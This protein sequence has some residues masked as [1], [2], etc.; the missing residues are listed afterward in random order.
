MRQVFATEEERAL[1]RRKRQLGYYYKDKVRHDAANR[2]RARNRYEECSELIKSRNLAWRKKNP[3][4]I[5]AQKERYRPRKA[6]LCRSLQYKGKRN[7]YLANIRQDPM[8]RFRDAVRGRIRSA[9]KASNIRKESLTE[10]MIG[11]SFAQLKGYLELKFL[12]GM[13]WNN[14]SQHGWHIDHIKP[15][16]LGK[17]FAE[18]SKLC[19]YTNLQPMWAKDN[20]QK[21]NKHG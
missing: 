6:Q 16:S 11:C 7:I 20:L 8:F 13:T 2:I 4:K 9:L 18:I 17:S 21:Y 14:H 5:K 12:P 3:D 1:A 10:T 19:H 15:L